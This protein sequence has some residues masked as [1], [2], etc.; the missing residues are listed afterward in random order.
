M[1]LSYSSGEEDAEGKDISHHSHIVPATTQ[2]SMPQDEVGPGVE[3]ET[4]NKASR[5]PSKPEPG[6][7]EQVTEPQEGAHQPECEVEK[8]LWAAVEDKQG[9]ENS[10]EKDGRQKQEEGSVTGG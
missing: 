6:P 2:P 3:L 7:Q 1:L 8:H 10:E 4:S 5:L 9:H